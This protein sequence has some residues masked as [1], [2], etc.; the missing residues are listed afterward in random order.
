MS[1]RWSFTTTP[2]TYNLALVLLLLAWYYWWHPATY[3][4]GQ[5]PIK[6]DPD[7]GL[8]HFYCL[9]P[10]WH[11][12]CVRTSIAKGD[13]FLL[14]RSWDMRPVRIVDGAAVEDQRCVA[15][16]G[17]LA[18]YV[19]GH[20]C[21][22]LPYG[23]ESNGYC[24][25]AALYC[26]RQYGSGAEVVDPAPGYAFDCGCHEGSVLNAAGTRCEPAAR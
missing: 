19:P 18:S 9:D 16:L 23:R 10:E 14:C 17:P 15:D 24:A 12:P 26:L 5:H 6:L 13:T 11:V 22:C 4:C 3:H 8:I 20:G 21:T 2:R 1:I 25:E 7:N